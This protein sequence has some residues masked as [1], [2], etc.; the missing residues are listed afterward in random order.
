VTVD[1][2]VIS[3]FR[4]S[5]EESGDP[6]ISIARSSVRAIDSQ[7]P[8]IARSSTVAKSVDQSFGNS[9]TLASAV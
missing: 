7:N 2:L 6:I 3:R 1:E 9:V 8:A 4:D 5:I